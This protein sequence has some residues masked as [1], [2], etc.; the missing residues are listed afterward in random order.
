MMWEALKAGV[1]ED[2]SLPPATVRAMV[3]R[4]NEPKQPPKVFHYTKILDVE[5]KEA[6]AR[7]KD[8]NS[9][10]EEEIEEE[11]EVEGGGSQALSL[12]PAEEDESER[13]ASAEHAVRRSQRSRVAANVASSGMCSICASCL[14]CMEL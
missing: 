11:E 6:R 10:G 5:A 13:D 3:A 14:L 4:A 7:T 9:S 2:Y 8:G 1:I 12:P